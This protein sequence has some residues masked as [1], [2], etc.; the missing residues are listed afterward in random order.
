MWRSKINMK[1]EK[2]TQYALVRIVLMLKGMKEIWPYK[3][4][5]ILELWSRCAIS[6]NK[7][8]HDENEGC[9][10]I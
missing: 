2:K 10:M 3:I 1:N 6:W 4:L 7:I 5:I 8:G 9:K